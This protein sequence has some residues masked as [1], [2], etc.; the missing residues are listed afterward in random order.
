MKETL[1]TAPLSAEQQAFLKNTDDLIGKAK[2]VALGIWLD[3]YTVG[4]VSLEA[5]CKSV[6]LALIRI[7]VSDPARQRIIGEMVDRALALPKPKRKRGKVGHPITLQKTIAKLVEIVVEREGLSKSR[8][9]GDRPT[10][11]QR[12]SEILDL[13]GFEVSPESVIRYYFDYREAIG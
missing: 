9:S 8:D 13:V 11:F 5:M 6:H 1:L 7:G 4:G 2:T 12:T 3:E 10:A